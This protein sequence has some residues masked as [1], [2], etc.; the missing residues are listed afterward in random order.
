MVRALLVLALV[1]TASARKPLPKAHAHNDY[2]HKRP[3]LDALEHGFCGVE[4]DIYLV[5]GELLVGHDR[6][7]LK[8]GRTLRK[9]YLDPLRKRVK[10]NKGQIYGGIKTEFTL[11]ID[12]KSD[13]KQTYHALSKVLS[14]YKEILTGTQ[15]GVTTKRAVTVIISGNRA[16]EKIVDDNPRYAGIDGRLED[17]ESGLNKHLLPLISD[18]WS[19]HFKWKGEGE[20]PA[21]E[22]QKLQAIVKQ[23]HAVGRSVRFW[24]TPEKVAVW[25]ELQAAGVDLINTDDLPGLRRFLSEDSLN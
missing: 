11:L 2:E 25:R 18:N 14:E 19:K 6:K 16:K 10:A 12:I 21:E 4:A 9:L 1:I 3:L 13:G 5:D 20:M 15:D 24:A 17:L 7:D 8:P 22:R 23:A